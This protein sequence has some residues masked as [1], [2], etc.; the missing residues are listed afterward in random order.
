VQSFT[1]AVRSEVKEFGVTVTALLPGATATDFFRKANMEDAKI[2]K[3]GD[4]D[5][6]AEVAKTG[7][8]ALKKGD[9]M[10]VTGFKN[11]LQV[12]MSK[13][14][15]DEKLADKTKKQQAPLKSEKN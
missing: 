3:E 2:I 7:Y 11:K 14:T 9:D 10:V 5:D 15:P 6:A 1:E 4:L 12:A 13:V 8:E